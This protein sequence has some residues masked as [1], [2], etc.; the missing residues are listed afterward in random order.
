[1]IL[2]FLDVPL[3]SSSEIFKPASQRNNNA[4]AVSDFTFAVYSI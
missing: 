4:V 1:M 2:V 3:V